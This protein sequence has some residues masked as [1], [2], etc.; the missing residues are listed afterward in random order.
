MDFVSFFFCFCFCLRVFVGKNIYVLRKNAITFVAKK[1]KN[2]KKVKKQKAKQR[3]TT[4]KKKDRVNKTVR[5]KVENEYC[6][7]STT[8]KQIQL[9][10]DASQILESPIYICQ[11]FYFQ[12]KKKL[13]T[14]KN[15]INIKTF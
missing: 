11:Q 9:R 15:K 8:T 7:K 5:L 1:K 2:K 4:T 14:K 3:D 6:C 13:H 10:E 12:T